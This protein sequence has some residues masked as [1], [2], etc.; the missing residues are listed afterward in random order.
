MIL[1]KKNNEASAKEAI[2]IMEDSDDEMFISWLDYHNIVFGMWKVYFTALDPEARMKE[3]MWL[4]KNYPT[5]RGFA[6]IN[7][8]EFIGKP[9]N[10][11]TLL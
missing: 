10:A 4:K 8:T 9:K 11:Q 2:V 7:A 3:G 5:A 1:L 6:R